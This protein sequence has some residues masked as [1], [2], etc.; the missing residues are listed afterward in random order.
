[1]HLSPVDAFLAVAALS[2]AFLLE[3]FVFIALGMI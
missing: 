1:M 3:I 2:T